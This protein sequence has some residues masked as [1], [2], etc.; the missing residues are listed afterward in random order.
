[1]GVAHSDIHHL[2]H[3]LLGSGLGPNLNRLSARSILH[4]QPHQ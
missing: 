3:H 1:M 2:D 4:T